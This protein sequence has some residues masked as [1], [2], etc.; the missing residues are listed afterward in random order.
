M[1]HLPIKRQT[2]YSNGCVFICSFFYFYGNRQWLAHVEHAIVKLHFYQPEQ[3][4]NSINLKS[5]IRKT[6]LVT[7]V[8]LNLVHALRIRSCV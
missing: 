2:Y 1:P 5:V 7:S 8:S 4:L 3:D 6:I